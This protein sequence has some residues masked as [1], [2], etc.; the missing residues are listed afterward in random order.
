MLLSK[1]NVNPMRSVRINGVQM[2]QLVKYLSHLDS[3]VISD[4]KCD[5]EISKRIGMTKTIFH[6]MSNVSKIGNKNKG[7]AVLRVVSFVVC[8]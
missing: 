5:K 8:M 2:L 3:F 1:S 4:V 7:T 6:S